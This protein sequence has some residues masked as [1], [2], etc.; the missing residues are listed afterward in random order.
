L[1][2]SIPNNGGN[3][4]PGDRRRGRPVELEGSQATAVYYQRWLPAVLHTVLCTGGYWFPDEKVRCRWDAETVNLL[5]V[6]A[7]QQTYAIIGGRKNGIGKD[8]LVA[9]AHRLPGAH[10]TG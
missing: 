3:P 8:E 7:H 2:I 1:V 4:S 6:D 5:L 9:I 10:P